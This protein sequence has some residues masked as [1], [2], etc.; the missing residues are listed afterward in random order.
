M[1][2]FPDRSKTLDRGNDRQVWMHHLHQSQGVTSAPLPFVW[3]HVWRGLLN[4]RTYVYATLYISIAMRVK[5]ILPEVQIADARAAGLST[6][7][8]SSCLPYVLTVIGGTLR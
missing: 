7:C 1:T 8:R 6:A 5:P 4:W 3:E 2:D